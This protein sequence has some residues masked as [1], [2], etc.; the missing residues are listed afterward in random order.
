M[1][2]I[3]ALLLSLHGVHVAPVYHATGPTRG[4]LGSVH[5]AP[6]YHPY[7]YDRRVR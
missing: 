2:W 3:F 6:V 4:R 5:V 1:I 7:A